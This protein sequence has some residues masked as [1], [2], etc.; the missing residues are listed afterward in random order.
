MRPGTFVRWAGIALIVW[1]L[2]WFVRDITFALTHGTTEN[3]MSRRF[4]GLSALDYGRLWPPIGL[5]G[6]VGLVGVFVRV[7]SRMGWAG[8]AGLAVAVLGLVL[9]FMSS[10]MQVWIVDPVAEFYSP[11]VYGGWLLSLVAMLVLTVG[12]ILAGLDIH[13]VA[14]LTE[15]RSLL[16]L[17]GLLFV[18]AILGRASLVGTYS[19]G[20]PL[21]SLL[22]V[23]LFVPCELCWLRFGQILI[24]ASRDNV[25]GDHTSGD[26]GPASRAR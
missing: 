5:L 17:S 25:L 1:A 7:R 19:D 26:P 14:A 23:G 18:P 11:W 3:D 12:L 9:L 8:R 16:L 22:Y 13:R 20:S 24:V 21:F 15:G 6:V 2:H 4:L 10:V